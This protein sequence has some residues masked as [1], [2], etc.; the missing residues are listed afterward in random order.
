MFREPN[1]KKKLILI[2][3][4]IVVLWSL[5]INH[6]SGPFSLSHIDP[7]FP[8][9]LNGL[10]CAILDFD[11]IGHIDHPGTPFQLLTGFFIRIIY[12]AAGK[13]PIVEDVI[14]RPE[15]YLAWS[16]FL[17]SVLTAGIIL[18]LGKIVLRQNNN[19]FGAVILQS[20][21][22]LNIV[23][24]DI[25]S[26]YIPDR[27]LMIY[28]LIFV[29]LCFKYF[30]QDE[31]KGKKFAIQSGI[32]M[33]IAFVTKFNFLPLL[34][35]PFFIVDKM[36][37]R[38]IYFVSFLLSAVI[39]FLPVYDKFSYYRRF[40]TG[41]LMHDGLYGQGTNQV[42]NIK[43]FL[44]NM[45]LIFE[46][47]TSFFIILLAAFVLLIIL[48]FK[49]SIRNKQKKEFLFII[50]FMFATA[51]SIVMVAKH[52]KNYYLTPVFSL[53]GFI[54]YILWRI[55]RSNFAFR[56]I[57]HVFVLLLLILVILS[58]VRLYPGY[59]YRVQRYHENNLTVSY[60]KRN[61]SSTDY[62]F[63]EP[64][65]MSGPMITNGLVYGVT[66]VGYKHY[67]Y[68][69]YEKI[70]PNIITWEGKDNPMK[71]FRMVDAD[72]EAILK[73]GKNI[74]VLSTPGRN[75]IKLINYLDNC[76]LN[77]GI[78]LSKD[79]VFTNSNKK[80]YII[81]IRNKDNWKTINES[82]CGFEKI[83][84]NTLS[85]DNE[86]TSL[87]GKFN[88]TG[89]EVCNG[90]NA[91]KLDSTIPVS[92]K[93]IINNISVGDYIEVTVKRRKNNNPKK[94]MLVL[95]SSAPVYDSTIFTESSSVSSVSA[96]WEIVRLNTEIN[97]QPANNTLSCFFRYS[98]DEVVFI[99]DFTFKHFKLMPNQSIHPCGK[100][101]E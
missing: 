44:H 20:S 15:M 76:A 22:F 23:L 86:K 55:S 65:W 52:F 83:Q 27:M 47:N 33:G 49:P 67:Y 57:K 63:I 28:V 1:Y 81:R 6:L 99:D 62:F 12:W 34:I 75:A 41:I 94:G 18:W 39:F 37:E 51:I 70:Y 61:I 42:I 56:Y 13:G 9:L 40:I 80:E 74:Y 90:S 59:S 96:K 10:N 26:R 69:D 19:L 91:L 93:Y 98:G 78:S 95:C 79:T 8:Y 46:Y 32:L 71:Y 100:I 73:S 48:A 85:T 30:Y 84:G 68:N 11:R 50:A 5:Y 53:T 43:S 87:I 29:G 45:S 36:K 58:I 101:S 24:I 7:E 3:P 16:S 88:L 89:K 4:A 82:R 31:F 77:M 21:V 35:I 92:P 14:S 64:S 66:Y 54:F 2:I 25:P 72:N 60:I 38:L 97:F 17:L